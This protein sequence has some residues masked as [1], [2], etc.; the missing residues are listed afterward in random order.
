MPTWKT[1]KDSLPHDEEVVLIA[2]KDHCK[3]TA[4]YKSDRYG[5]KFWSTPF[6]KW[7]SSRVSAWCPFPTIDVKL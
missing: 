4:R 1:V 6:G 7:S 3:T 5:N 2:T